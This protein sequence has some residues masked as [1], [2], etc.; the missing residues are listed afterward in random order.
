MFKPKPLISKLTGILSGI[1]S[2]GSENLTIIER[3]DDE[4]TGSQNKIIKNYLYVN[5]WKEEIDEFADCI[6]NIKP[7]ENGTC[8]DALKVMKM[9]FEI[10][11]ADKIWWKY[12]NQN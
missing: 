11:K 8:G 10:Y 1:K 4:P 3:V 9:I 7:I 5:S 2:H 12:F 6:V